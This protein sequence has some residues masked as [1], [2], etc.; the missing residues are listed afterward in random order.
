MTIFVDLDGVLANFEGEV[1][2]LLGPDSDWKKEIECPNWGRITEFQDIYL[3]LP[4][5]PD[6]Y[7]LWDYLTDN[8]DAP[9]IQILTA[10][11]RRAHFPNAVNHKREWVWANFGDHVKVNF[12][13]YAHD[14]QFHYKNGDILIDDMVINCNQWRDRGGFSVCHTSAEQT[15]TELHR[16]LNSK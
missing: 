11:P 12:G 6:A 3:N 9:D 10:I 4:L 7:E 2:Q 14:K 13:P 5:M 15:V 8:F 16:K 1:Q